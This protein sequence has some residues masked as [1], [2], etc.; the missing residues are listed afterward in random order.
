MTD[1][2]QCFAIGRADYGRL[3]IGVTQDVES[4][5]VIETL[6]KIKIVDVESGEYISYA[7]GEKQEFY[8]WGVGKNQDYLTPTLA[9]IENFKIFF[10]N[11]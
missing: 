2:N 6:N 4:L 8:Y 5:K 1:N 7:I 11:K 3:G 10:F 9:T